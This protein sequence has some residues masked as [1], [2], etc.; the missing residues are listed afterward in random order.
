MKLFAILGL[1][2]LLFQEASSDIQTCRNTG[3]GGTDQNPANCMCQMAC[4]GDPNDHGASNN[5]KAKC[6]TYCRRTDCKCK[7]PCE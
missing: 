2:L 3:K 7:P 5:P 6:K 4:S 1:A